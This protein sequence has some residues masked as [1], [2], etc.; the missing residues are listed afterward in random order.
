MNLKDLKPRLYSTFWDIV[1]V[2][3]QIS[4]E[5]VNI[6][7]QELWNIVKHK[8]QLE[9]VCLQARSMIRAALED[10]YT[11]ASFRTYPVGE[12]PAA[13]IP[14]RNVNNVGDTELLAIQV[15]N[16]S[17]I[18]YT[19]A[20]QIKMTDDS[21][22][23]VISHLEGNQGTGETGTDFTSSNGD[24]TILSTAWV[25]NQAGLKNE[26]EFWFTI[27]DVHPLIWA[28]SVWL[29]TSFAL[30]EIY[31]VESP[32]ES[33]FG[34]KLFN[35]AKALLSKLQ[36]PYHKD[37]YR[38]FSFGQDALTS[39]PVIYD[40]NMYGQDVSPYLDTTTVG[41]TEI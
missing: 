17:V 21:N 39:V 36:Q 35:R 41:E 12:I 27:Y 13:T 25:S 23:S 5:Q 15:N 11:E 31:T 7:E 4:T 9:S 34:A 10:L 8:A 40:V 38:L 24:V 3:Q 19:A 1:S 28:I 30:D 6:S 29:S 33:N 32:N 16:S 14:V 22:F 2:A 26:D 18:P 37:G 20:W